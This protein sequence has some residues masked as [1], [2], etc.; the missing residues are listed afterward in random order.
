MNASSRCRELLL[1]LRD[2]VIHVLPTLKSFH[3]FFSPAKCWNKTKLWCVW[4]NPAG[5]V[6]LGTEQISVLTGK[7]R[8]VF[9][10]NLSI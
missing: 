3:L 7:E 2:H 10:R 5:C 1:I 4:E 8:K 6:G 9:G